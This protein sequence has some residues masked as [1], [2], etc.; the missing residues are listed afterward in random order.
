MGNYLA[1]YHLYEAMQSNIKNSK[2]PQIAQR[3]SRF[4]KYRVERV[5]PIQTHD[6]TGPEALR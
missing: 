2:L 1:S 4:P 5:F 6:K 3:L